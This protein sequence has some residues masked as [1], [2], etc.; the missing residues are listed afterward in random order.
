MLGVA[1][2]SVLA[3]VSCQKDDDNL[4]DL[5]AVIADKPA[6]GAKVT[7]DNERYACWS[8]GDVVSIN[9]NEYT[10]AITNDGS[11]HVTISGV[12]YNSDGYAAVY[13]ASCHKT[14]NA[15]STSAKIILPDAQEWSE[16]HIVTPMVAYTTSGGSGSTLLFHNPCNLLKVT[17]TNGL[18]GENDLDI[19]QII[20]T[21]SNTILTGEATVTGLDGTPS[22]S[23]VTG[24]TKD[25]TLDCG[26]QTIAAGDH[27]TFYVTV[28]KVSGEQFRFRVL[29]KNGGTKYTFDQESQEGI[30]LTQNE[31]VPI[32]ISLDTPNGDN[33]F[34]GSGTSS[35]PF[36]I[37][38][39]TDL[40]TLRT[41]TNEGTTGY[42]GSG[43]YYRQTA[44]ITL[45]GWGDTPIGNQSTKT[46]SSNY[47]G[48][49]H[50]IK[51]LKITSA[52]NSTGLFGYVSAGYIKN[53]T[54]SGSIA[55]N[56]TKNYGGIIGEIT[57]SMT[58]EDCTS[59]VNITNNS[60]TA[61]AN[62]MGGIVGKIASG[63]V[64]IKS[65]RNKGTLTHVRYYTGGIVGLINGPKENKV[66][67]EKCYNEKK[68]SV[69]P[70]SGNTAYACM[71]G[72]ICGY[73]SNAYDVEIS[74]C[75][76]TSDAVIDGR[77]SY[78]S[79]AS[80][81]NTHLGGILGMN[82]TTS[83]VKLKSCV[84]SGEIWAPVKGHRT[85][86]LVGRVQDKIEIDKCA[87]YGD[88]IGPNTASASGNERYA[89]GFIGTVYVLSNTSTMSVKNSV[90]AGNIYNCGYCGGFVA[91]LQHNSQYQPEFNNCYA[92]CN[93]T[94]KDAGTGF[95]F[96]AGAFFHTITGTT[97]SYYTVVT[98][99]NC[100]YTGSM[101]NGKSTTAVFSRYCY[102]MGVGASLTVNN[103]Y[104]SN[105]NGGTDDVHTPNTNASH[106]STL[107]LNDT[108]LFDP[109]TGAL[110]GDPVVVN[111]TN[112]TTLYS[113]LHNWYLANTTDHVDWKEETIPHLSWEPSSK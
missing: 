8:D 109:T 36:L 64:T 97:N 108:R 37:T 84:N 25:V 17:V 69:G 42:V 62:S 4:V 72:G 19:H 94:N 93:I 86:G 85:G 74:E 96:Y 46:F 71:G 61:T 106:P 63:A 68:I 67:I 107:T 73:V 26:D 113:A 75:E 35:D 104:L 10:V 29:A 79:T 7:I 112:C 90:S 59:E 77:A 27:Y 38:D 23:S 76:N 18:A 99:N 11:T 21:S 102:L 105:D 49:K 55:C 98:M 53:L 91:Y 56:S 54:V 70:R 22:I 32:S 100:Y 80:N 65:C 88:I 82:V 48:G 31:M 57:G 101:S 43:K 12:T 78:Q 13:P 5:T 9:G 39:Q 1:A 92:N 40:E 2:F 58:I 24:G 33:N 28:P 44:D 16:G 52:S 51:S 111:G 89:G 47:D 95:N 66:S 81:D 83:L 20:V 60:T 45:S 6:S 41:K 87:F 110:A 3:A 34:W 30:T 50:R 103:G 14:E 15:G